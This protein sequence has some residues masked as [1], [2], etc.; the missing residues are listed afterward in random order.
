M[1]ALCSEAQV[2]NSQGNGHIWPMLV[3]SRKFGGW[4]GRTS[5]RRLRAPTSAGTD[6]ND[7]I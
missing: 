6:I 1:D 7:A 3:S 2:R 4:S 5:W